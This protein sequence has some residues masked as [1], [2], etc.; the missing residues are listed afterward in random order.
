MNMKFLALR[1]S[2]VRVHYHAQLRHRN[3]LWG[4]ELETYRSYKARQESIIES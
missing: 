1:K 2:S 3:I 4:G